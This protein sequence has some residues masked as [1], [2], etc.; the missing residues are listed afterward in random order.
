MNRLSAIRLFASASFVAIALAG[1]ALAASA[2][3][4]QR[5]VK[6]GTTLPATCWAGDVFF[7]TNAPAGSNLF[8]CVAPNTWVTQGVQSLGGDVTG[9][10]SSTRVTQIQGRAVSSTAPAAGQTL[11][12]NA[13]TSRWEPQTSAAAGSISL[14]GDA[15]GPSTGVTVVQLQG[16]S[17]ASTTPQNG[18]ALIWNGSTNRWEPQVVSTTSVA[19]GAG[20]SMATQ[21]GD[22]A[23]TRTSDA[24]L[25]IGSN[26]S[27]TTPCNVR[28]GSVVYSMTTPTTVNLSSGSGNALVYISSSGGA[29]IGHN[30]TLTCTGNCTAQSGVT[31]FPTDSIPI[32]NW[33]ALNGVWDATGSDVRSVLASRNISPGSGLMTTDISG[34]TAIAADPTL[35][36]LRTSVPA[37]AASACTAGT[38][39]MDSNYYYVCIGANSWKRAALA[40]W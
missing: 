11:V 2:N 10:P 28:Y 19:G 7:N 16:R 12:W 36:S 8:T 35:I 23:V 20:A 31:A 38:W 26:C 27:F 22:L 40:A 5:A 15:V 29:T 39:A 21:L 18:Q 37:T 24:T 3:V 6:F 14:A 17:V 1:P 33:H 34:T 32:C 30:L 9:A 4:D 25:T 13:S